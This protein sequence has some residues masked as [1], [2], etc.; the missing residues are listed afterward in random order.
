MNNS[1]SSKSHDCF[2]FYAKKMLLLGQ[3]LEINIHFREQHND[4][5]LDLPKTEK[6]KDELDS[7][8]VKIC[9]FQNLNLV[10][11]LY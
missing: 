5:H 2:C 8:Q 4:V 7:S 9:F 1:K 11:T 3:K 10:F 6:Q